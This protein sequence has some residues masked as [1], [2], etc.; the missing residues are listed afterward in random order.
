MSADDALL[1]VAAT[2]L[3]AR[4]AASMDDVARAVGVSRVTPFRRFPSRSTL[5]G[6]LCRQAVEA[7][8]AATGPAGAEDGDDPVLALRGLV[9]RL[10]PLGARY[11]RLITQPPEEL[12]EQ[13]LLARAAAGEERVRLLVRRGQEAGV[14]RVDVDPEWVLTVLTWLVVGAADGVRLGRL[15]PARVEPSVADTVLRLVVRDAG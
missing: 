12:V 2:L 14:F 15:A 9:G 11:G 7:F 13:D 1:D 10:V 3:A 8:I 6:T 4:P 5:I